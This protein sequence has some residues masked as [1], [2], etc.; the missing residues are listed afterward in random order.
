[1]NNLFSAIAKLHHKAFI[2][3]KA[4]LS[5]IAILFLWFLITL[6]PAENRALPS[7]IEVIKAF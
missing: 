3:L 7:P 1:M 6:T 4:W 5:T 2:S